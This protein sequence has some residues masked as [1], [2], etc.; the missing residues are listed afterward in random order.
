MRHIVV[1]DSMQV[2]LRGILEPVELRDR[3]GRVV[4]HYTPVVTPEVRATYDKAKEMMDP[5]EFD[6]L[7]AEQ[8]DKAT[9]IG[10]LLERLRAAEKRG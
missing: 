9:P 4:G 2:R 6:R 8:G 10:P 3:E 1:D 7:L 5:A